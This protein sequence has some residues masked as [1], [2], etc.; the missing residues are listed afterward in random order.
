[1]SNISFSVLMSVYKNELPENLKDS[2]DSVFNNTLLPSEVI[3]VEDGPL[4][5]GLY[6][7]LKEYEEKYKSLIRI[8]INKNLGLGQA[9]N[10]GLDY[11]SNEFI[12]RMDTDDLCLLNRFEKQVQFIQDNPEVDILSG[13]V[14]EFNDSI[15]NITGTKSVPLTHN[16]IIKFSKIRSPFNHMAVAYKKS[17]IQSVGGYQH[18]LYMEDYNLWLRVLSA[19]F[20]SANLKDTLVLVRAGEDMVKRR[21]GKQYLKSEWQLF[22]LKR[23]LHYQPIP[24]ALLIY[25]VRSV[26]RL[27]PT[28]ILTRIYSKLR[29]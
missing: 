23:E 13:Q 2:L 11:C 4:T 20:K 29:K 10:I 1:M 22:K 19:G 17:V 15:E 27:L 12:F 26:P 16:D 9:L 8:R 28:S 18:H 5:E 3:I 7:I 25:I 21:R 14:I 6:L 24:Q